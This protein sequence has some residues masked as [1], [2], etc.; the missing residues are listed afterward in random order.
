MNK[1]FR[2]WLSSRFF[3]NLGKQIQ[4]TVIA[5]QIFK[6]TNDPLALG[7]LGLAEAVPFIGIALWAGHLVDRREKRHFILRAQIGLVASSVVLFLTTFM[8]QPPILI[9]YVITAWVGLCA[10]FE[11]I[12]TSAYGQ[13]LIPKDKFPWAMGWNL[14]LFQVASLAGPPLA[15]YLLAHVEARS[16]YAV[17]AVLLTASVISAMCLSPIHVQTTGPAEE[18]GLDRVKHGLK[19]IWSQPLI[20][21]AMVL[22]MVA[23]LF[24]DVVALYP[25]FADK[26]GAGSVGFGFLKAASGIGSG[27]VSAAQA[28]KQFVR[29]SWTALRWV[30]A[31]FGLCI[32]GFALS[33]NIYLAVMFIAIGGA[34]DGISV[35]IRQTTYQA[36]TPDHLR[37]RVASVSSIFIWTSNELGAFESGL[38]ARFIGVV[39]SALVGGLICVS[40]VFVMT[41]LFRKKIPST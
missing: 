35:I 31:V 8:D 4:E 6:L 12:S 2:R 34:A 41:Y 38:V 28:I 30:V 7:F 40:S 25:F 1:G 29:P 39:P 14:G 24:G 9:F 22:D 33:P 11:N 5:W 16:I 17:I 27:F 15:G 21:S 36:L 37:G 10:S 26:W 19:F 13:L 20:L 3:S 18:S 32:I 23:V